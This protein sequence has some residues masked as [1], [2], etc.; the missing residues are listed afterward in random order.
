MLTA[1]IP[2]I[3]VERLACRGLEAEGEGASEQGADLL[4]GLEPL[5][6]DGHDHPPMIP[7]PGRLQA[8][9]T[10]ESRSP[11]R[12]MCHWKRLKLDLRGGIRYIVRR[13]GR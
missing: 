6:L 2:I 9:F 5:G 7:D 13:F 4:H 8:H 11:F 10:L 3:L 1:P 12:L